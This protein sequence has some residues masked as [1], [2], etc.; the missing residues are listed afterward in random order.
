MSSPIAHT[1]VDWS[2]VFD[3]A[4]WWSRFWTPSTVTS[5]LDSVDGDVDGD[6]NRPGMRSA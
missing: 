4:T 2:D 5:V 3:V 1:S 6:P